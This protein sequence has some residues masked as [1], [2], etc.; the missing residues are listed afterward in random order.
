MILNSYIG[1]YIIAICLSMTAHASLEQLVD[2]KKVKIMLD[3]LHGLIYSK[4]INF[5][6]VSI[7]SC[8]QSY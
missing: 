6:G 5:K 8:L 7:C 2:D 1:F 4:L 3:V